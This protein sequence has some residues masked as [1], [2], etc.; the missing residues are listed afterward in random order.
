MALFRS[1]VIWHLHRSLH[2]LD[3]PSISR[4]F[5][6][7]MCAAYEVVPYNSCSGSGYSLMKYSVHGFGYR[8]M[9]TC[10]YGISLII[11]KPG[12]DEAMVTSLKV[13][14]SGINLSGTRSMS[15]M[16]VPTGARQ[17]ALKVTML[18]PGFVYEP[19][20]PREP[21]PFWRRWFTPSG[22]R[23]T[24]ED[25]I[26]EMKS[27]YAISRLRKVTGYSK[28][29]FYE[30]AVKLYKEINTLMADRDTSSL[31]KLVTEKMYS[32]LKNE[33]KRRESMWSSVHWELI[34]PIVSIRTLRARMIALDK[35]DLD[36]S[37]VQLTIEFTSKQRFE[38]YD[39]KGG[40][41]SGDK[42]KEV[43]VRDIWVFERSLFHPGAEWRLCSR[44][45]L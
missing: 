31:R 9:A 44:I 7:C 20:A 8:G 34:E 38:A 26:L 42:T 3:L 18:S 11:G 1:K 17:V 27:A 30:H 2:H 40:V 33:I 35:N 14:E 19:Y 10:S 29:I 5:Q 41:I 22:W 12:R 15:T 23:R 28:K 43:L 6:S 37:F 39:S 32:T 4:S 24:K 13:I 36:K 21:I 25:L 16:K 45:T